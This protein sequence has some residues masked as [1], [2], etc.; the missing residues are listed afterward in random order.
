MKQFHVV[1][2]GAGPVGVVAAIAAAQKGFKVT[3]LESAKEVDHNPRAATTHPSTLEFINQVGLID[4]FIE[5]G[6]VARYFQFWDRDTKSRV[7]QFDH[8]L[9][10]DETKFPFVVQT[11]QHKLVLMGLKRLATFPDVSYQFGITVTN[12]QQGPDQVTLTTEQDGVMGQITADYVIGSDGGKST[13][14]KLL[15][16]E[17]E[18][19]TWPE[20]F[21]VLTSIHDFEKSM[22]CCYRNYFAG[23]SEWA[24]LFKVTG[25]DYKGRWRAVFPARTDE[26][27]EEA[28]SDASAQKRIVELEEA[29]SLESI[30]HRNIYNVHQRVAQKFRV[31]RVMLAGDSSH[32]NNPIG[33][34][35]LNCGI[36]DAMELVSSLEDIRNG[37]DDTRL[38]LYEKRRKT[39]NVQFIQEQTIANKKRLEEKDPLARQQRLD[40]LRKIEAD[41][42][43]QKQFLMKS[44]LLLSVINEKNITL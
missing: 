44:S 8:D 30:V 42:Q 33:G 16:I 10:K 5:Q 32:L 34:L 38:D 6:L 24:N 14:R 11:E 37:A 40:E 27:D 29:C 31:G 26:S 23:S 13:I 41:N 25:D 4:E 9:L 35:G 12:L 22:G 43:L 39:L 36:H 21:I 1:V 19:Y 17:F 28:L 18:G 3:L 2:V 15:N 7:A 20:R